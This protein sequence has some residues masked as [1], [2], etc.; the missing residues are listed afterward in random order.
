MPTRATTPA[1]A[2]A[3]MQLDMRAIGCFK[4]LAIGDA[5]GKQAETLSPVMSAS[6]MDGENHVQPDGSV[7]IPSALRPYFNGQE[8]IWPN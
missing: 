1:T 5:I 3:S 4:A 8:Y 7:K 2:E 6:D